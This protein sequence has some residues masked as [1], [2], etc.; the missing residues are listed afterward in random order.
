MFEIT[1]PEVTSVVI[2][3]PPWPQRSPKWLLRG[4]MHMDTRVIKVTDFTS[5]VK[6]ASEIVWR[7]PRSMRPPTFELL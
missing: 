3:R 6:W 5:E 4:N 2:W 7:P 1:E